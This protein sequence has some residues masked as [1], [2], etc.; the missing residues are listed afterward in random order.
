MFSNLCSHQNIQHAV[1]LH[2]WYTQHSASGLLRVFMFKCSVW[3][4]NVKKLSPWN[5]GLD[6]KDCNLQG[7]FW[8]KKSSFLL[9]RQGCLVF[10]SIAVHYK[11]FNNLKRKQK[12]I[13]CITHG[14]FP[15]SDWSMHR[16]CWRFFCSDSGIIWIYVGQSTAVSQ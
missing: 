6:E 1:N 7:Q 16:L 5:Y 2:K 10:S 4:N 11:P 8:R 14:V 15:N 3:E 9:C 13:C 12:L